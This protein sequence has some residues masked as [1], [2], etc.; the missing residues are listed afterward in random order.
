MDFKA[1]LNSLNSVNYTLDWKAN[2]KEEAAP[3]KPN[4]CLNESSISQICINDNA[5]SSAF[6]NTLTIP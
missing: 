3:T 1:F 4:S 5:G 2:T 6:V